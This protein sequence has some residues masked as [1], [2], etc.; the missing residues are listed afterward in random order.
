MR[1]PKLIPVLL[2]VAALLV[3]Q[4]GSVLAA[5]ARQTSTPPAPITGTVQTITIETDPST[6]A[7]TVVVTILDGTGATQT[8]RLS[9]DTAVAL[10]LVTIDPTTGQPVVNSAAVGTQVSID[11]GTVIPEPTTTST[12]HPV[13]SALANFFSE[14]LGVDYETIMEYHAE[15]TG[16]GVIAQ[17][18]W[19]TKQLEGD[20]TVFAAI[21]DAKKSGDY[22]AITLPDGSTPTNWGQFRKALLSGDK[23][24]NLGAIMSGRAESGGGTTPQADQPGNGNGNGHGNGHGNGGVGHG[25]GHGPKH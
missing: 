18:L 16:F 25:K 8:L 9:V 19:M 2:L 23:K 24:A 6:G 17:A 7:T 14:L 21:L 3:V 10:G 4:F 22:S 1:K 11:P 5:P 12:Q 13:G 15:G 20:S